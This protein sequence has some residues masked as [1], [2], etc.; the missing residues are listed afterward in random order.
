[1]LWLLL[2]LPASSQAGN[3]NIVTER[4]ENF[5]DVARK[6]SGVIMDMRYASSVNFVGTPIDGYNNATCLLTKDAASALQAVQ[7][8]LAD[9]KLTL[10]IFDCYRPQ[11]AVDHFVRWAQHLNDTPTKPDHY[12]NVEKSQLFAQ[13][14][15]A[16]RSGHSRGSTLDLTLVGLGGK[17]AADELEM[18]TDYDYFDPASHTDSKLV[19]DQ[20]QAN[21]QL[22]KNAMEE[23][24]FVSLPEEWWHF[25]LKNEPYPD[26]YF[27]FEVE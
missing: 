3:S 11:R 14:Y 19:D 1:M 16:E 21:R 24:G 25:T 23:Q 15:I 27:D 22:L 12:P 2:L 9:K 18:G 4:P 17:Y 20:A 10:K 13:G 6:V 26:T 5:V 8:E 7:Q